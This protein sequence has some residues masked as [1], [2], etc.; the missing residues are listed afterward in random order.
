MSSVCH[1]GDPHA[2]TC[3]AQTPTRPA[4]YYNNYP[5]PS[6]QVAWPNPYYAPLPPQALDGHPPFRQDSLTFENSFPS[7][8]TTAA[9]GSAPS[10]A[11]RAPFA[12]TTN[13]G[14]PPGP[15]ATGVHTN[16]RKSGPGGGNSRSRQRRR[17]EPAAAVSDAV[18]GVGPATAANVAAAAAASES[19]HHPSLP[20]ANLG[21]VVEKGEASNAVATDVWYF[22]REAA[23]GQPPTTADEPSEEEKAEAERLAIIEDEHI[24]DDE[25]ARYEAEGILD[26]SKPE[27]E[28][29][30][31]LGY[32]EASAVPCERVFSSSKETDALRRGSL[33]PEMMEMLQI[34][35][36]I[37]RQDRISFCDAWVATETELSVIDIDPKIIDELLSAG[38]TRELE[39]LLES[40]WETPSL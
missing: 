2:C 7:S 19:V 22:M 14:A 4:F 6:P 3:F 1:C 17:V 8:F 16:K 9:P 23:I 12:D 21:S 36:F 11:L 5:S 37:Y 15:A 38:K 25:L 27:F 18:F 10:P 35:K 30:S 33:S 13:L 24:V 34:L 26:E 39:Q 32:W 20:K 28:N 31:L 40:S 29:F